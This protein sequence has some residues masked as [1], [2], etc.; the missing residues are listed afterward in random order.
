MICKLYWVLNTKLKP[1]PE[2][3]PY[4]IN[5]VS[6]LKTFSTKLFS[7]FYMSPYEKCEKHKCT[8]A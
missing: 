1:N 4:L 6:Y 7:L 2:Q 5:R 3:V 8:G